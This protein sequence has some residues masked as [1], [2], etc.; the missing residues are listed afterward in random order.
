V[1]WAIQLIALESMIGIIRAIRSPVNADISLYY[2]LG[3]FLVGL[4]L[5]LATVYLRAGYVLFFMLRAGPSLFGIR[6]AERG[7]VQCCTIAVHL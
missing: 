3:G 7:A 5:V 4:L 1:G 2:C 6:A